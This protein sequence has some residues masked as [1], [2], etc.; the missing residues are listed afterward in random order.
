MDESHERDSGRYVLF[1]LGEEHYGLPIELVSS[2]IR[3]E[4]ATPVPHAPAA[5]EGVINLRGRV[6]PVVNLKRR[7]RDAPYE[8]TPVSRI[9]VAEGEGGSVG[10]A[11]DAANEVATIAADDVK[12][13]PET[14]LSPE[15]AEAFLGVAEHEGKLVI[16]LNL[17]RALPRGEYDTVT[18]QEVE[19]DG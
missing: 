19:A 7:L 16:L 10:L 11:V 18:A 1:R 2:I 17:D 14:A 4:P 3:Y 13:P 12:P 15:T 8:P 5:V 9:V 6:I